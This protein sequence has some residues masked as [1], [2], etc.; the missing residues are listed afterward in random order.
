MGSRLQE[1]VSE[2]LEPISEVFF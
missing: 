1:H 2:A